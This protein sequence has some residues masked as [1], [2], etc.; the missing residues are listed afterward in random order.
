MA[1]IS[2]KTEDEKA[3]EQRTRATEQDA[4][5]RRQQEEEATRKR[6]LFFDTP[7][8]RARAAFERGDQVFQYSANVMLQKAIIVAMVGSNTSRRTADPS[9]ILNSVCNEG[10]DLVSG[11][12]VFVETGQQSRDKF[13][14][15]GQ[16]V[17]VSGATIGYYLFRRAEGNKLDTAAE[18]WAAD[19]ENE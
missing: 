2:R 12:F 18:P 13:L 3:A 7:A 15:S 16:N 6:L 14:A 10:W 17:A 8:G 1:L 5:R 11:S 19:S 9:E 4:R